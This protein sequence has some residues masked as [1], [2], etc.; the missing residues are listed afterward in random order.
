MLGLRY[1]LEPT[2]VM[3]EEEDQHKIVYRDDVSI[4]GHFH[5]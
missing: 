1:W 5:K 4:T 3:S 2:I